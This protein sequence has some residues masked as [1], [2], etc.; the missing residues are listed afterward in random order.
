MGCELATN[1]VLSSV[2]DEEPQLSHA[3][4]DVIPGKLPVGD[5]LLFEIILVPNPGG[6]SKQDAGISF[7][8]VAG[9]LD[10]L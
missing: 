9:G 1:F 4:P 10:S 3:D 6:K 2:A 5:R 7:V 8:Y